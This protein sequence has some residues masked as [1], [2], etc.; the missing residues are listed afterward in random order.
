MDRAQLAVRLA[1]ADAAER[2]MLLAGPDV[3]PTLSL[4]WALQ[5]LFGEVVRT[6]PSQ[7]AGAAAALAQLAELYPD[8]MVEA[9]A[10]WTT[11]RASLHLDGQLELAVRR[12]DQARAEFIALGQENQAA[13]VEVS[14]LIALAL[15]GRYD[16]AIAAGEWARPLL[17]DHGDLLSAGRIEQNLGMIALR[18][19]RYA[20]AESLFLLARDRYQQL[21]DQAQLAQIENNLGL[22]LLYQHRF[23]EAQPL[24]DHALARAV[25]VGR[26]LTQAE[27]ECNLG[28]LALAT[29]RY[30]RALDLLEQARRRYTTLGLTHKAVLTEQELADAYLEINLIP[31]AAGIYT[32]IVPLLSEL[33]LRADEA[34]GLTQHAWCQLLLGDYAGARGLLDEANRLFTDE[35]NTVGV[36]LV[37]LAE[38]HLS[39]A[40][41]ANEAAVAAANRAEQ[42]LT[43]AGSTIRSLQARW[44]QGE[45]LRRLG[46]HQASLTLLTTAL[47]AAESQVVPPVIQ[48]CQTSL[49]LLA[50]ATGQPAQAEAAFQ[51]AIQLIEELR[52]PLPAEEFRMAFVADKMTPYTELV[53]LCLADNTAPRLAEA[54]D[55]VERA[56]SRALVELLSGA[57]MARPT[58]RDAFETEL[59]ERLAAVREELNWFYNQINRPPSGDSARGPAVMT[60]LQAAIQTRETSFQELTRQLRLRGDRPVPLTPAF[61]LSDLQ[62]AL[63]EET[64]LVEYFSLDGEL[65]AF[66]ITGDRLHVH[67]ALGREAEIDRAIEQ[68]HFQFGTL[69]HG[70]TSLESHLEQ[71]TQRTQHYLQ[72]LYNLLLH[73][74]EPLLGQR[75]LIVAPHRRLHYVPFH[76]LFDGREYVND[77]REVAYIP[78]ADL[79]RHCLQL[80]RR[81]LERVVLFGVQ[82]EEIPRVDDEIAALVELFPAATTRLG[83]AASRAALTQ[84]AGQADLLHL[85]CHGR[86]RPDNPLF[87]SVRLADGWLTVGDI[88]QLDLT[89]QL[90]T[91]SA[92][93]TGVN[94][95]MAGDELIGLARGFLAGGVPSLVVSLWTVDDESTALLMG[96]FYRRLRDG[97]SPAAALRQAQCQLRRRNP[98]PF[99]WSPFIVLGRW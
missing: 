72:V 35:G 32:R 42:S 64:A 58:P 51:R 45:A 71:L 77:R 94:A 63:G 57:L 86:F 40:E 38:A 44:L 12:L 7:A 46:Q 67:R 96:D 37:T 87:S 33:G 79:L 27:I 88:Y 15:A 8:Q 48:R 89:S 25:T 18:R 66:V 22:V 10:H 80:P 24:F 92:C 95:V 55:Y 93:E 90:V 49:G 47:A 13:T 59:M 68:L 53:R 85:A 29:G 14:R 34:R 21:D 73:P 54:L 20:E 84:L 82:D 4:A 2:A 26:Q 6:A 11:G 60:E 69:R 74:I 1:T 36:A 28:G 75:R 81:P 70:V 99:F 17:I 5:T 83:A 16:E 23:R 50:L 78:S 61:K 31:E 91:L 39:L 3:Q 97:A 9:L 41:E 98:H 56:R 52:A 76:A 43:T 62:E 65:S 19:D 30:D